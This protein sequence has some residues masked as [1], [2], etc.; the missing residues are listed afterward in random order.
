MP[1]SMAANQSLE[2]LDSFA[3]SFGP[4][5]LVGSESCSRTASS[6]ASP[7]ASHAAPPCKYSLSFGADKG[8]QFQVNASNP[9]VPPPEP[10][11][12]DDSENPKTREEK[13]KEMADA[14]INRCVN[15]DQICIAK[16]RHIEEL[17]DIMYST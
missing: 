13:L 12:S 9:N 10:S 2:S 17:Y 5:K 15:A 11:E 16:V 4:S 8:N 6:T 3:S 14:L 1:K 7:L